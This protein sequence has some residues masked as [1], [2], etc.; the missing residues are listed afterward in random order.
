MSGCGL[1]RVRRTFY[2]MPGRK[3]RCVAGD[4][5]GGEGESFVFRA[6]QL[7]RIITLQMNIL[8]YN[9]NHDTRTS[10]LS[11]VRKKALCG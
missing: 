10:N 2:K 9:L 8:K 4:D 11:L 5:G 6:V 1:Q 7:G 3:T